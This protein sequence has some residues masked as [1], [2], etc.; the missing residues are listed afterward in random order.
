MPASILHHAPHHIMVEG[1]KIAYHTAGEASRPP[2]MLVHG[3]LSHSRVWRRQ[4]EALKDRYFCVSVDLLG[5]GDSDSPKGGDYSIAAQG[6]RVLAVADALNLRQFALMGHSMG[7]QIALQIAA[8]LAP[9]RVTKLIHVC[10]VLS[11]ALCWWPKYISKNQMWLAMVAPILV[12]PTAAMFRLS[13]VGN[14]VFGTWFHKRPPLSEW[15]EDRE[16]TLQTSVIASGYPAV[17]ELQ[18]TDLTPHLNSIQAKTL[19]MVGRHDRVVPTTEGQKIAETM[20]DTRLYWF[21]DCGHFPHFEEEEHF[22]RVVA[23]F[24]A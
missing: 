12:P 2:L 5:F 4:M 3:W 6:R 11:G 15:I 21:E 16:R 22:N 10:G 1:H 8:V 17:V 14:V 19:V 20:P 18:K 13:W 23:E 7:G 24:L 9:E